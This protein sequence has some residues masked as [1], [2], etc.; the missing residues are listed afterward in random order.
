MSDFCTDFSGNA[1]RF[2][3]TVL[4]DKGRG[5]RVFKICSAATSR[6]VGSMVVLLQGHKK[7]KS[8]E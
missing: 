1:V 2:I 4:A 6:H 5:G 3:S 8:I 7:I